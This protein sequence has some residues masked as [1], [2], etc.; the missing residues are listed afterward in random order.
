MS[1]KRLRKM[2][3]LSKSEL[4]KVAKLV[5]S[6]GAAAAASRFGVPK[7]MARLAVEALA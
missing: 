2:T 5:A 7:W 3:G 4:K 1:I 6:I